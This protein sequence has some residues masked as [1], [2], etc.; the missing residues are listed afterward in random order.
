MSPLT[1]QTTTVL[2]ESF[3]L[4]VV[5]PAGWSEI[6]LNSSWAD[7]W[8]PAATIFPGTTMRAWVDDQNSVTADSLLVTPSLDFSSLSEA[9]VHFM[10]ETIYPTWR[11]NHPQSAG[12]GVSTVEYSV[13]GGVTWVVAWTD[14]TLAFGDQVWE[15]ADLSAAAGAPSVLVAFHYYGTDAHQWYVDNVVVD[16]D[17]FE[18]ATPWAVNLPTTFLSA[19][20]NEG[21][22][23][24]AGVLQPYMATTSVDCLT[25]QPDPTALCNIGQQNTIYYPPATGQFCLELGRETWSADTNHYSNAFVLGVDGQG[26]TSL[27]LNARIINFNDERDSLDGIWISEDGLG[28]YRLLLDWRDY[29]DS[30]WQN[31]TSI[32]L[33]NNGVD[34]GGQFYIMFGQEDQGA[35]FHDDGIGI[36]DIAVGSNTA[37]V[38]TIS[39]LV[40]GAQATFSISSAQAG[41]FVTIG[42]SL[43]GAGPTNTQY[44]FVDMTSPISVLA[45]LQANGQGV[46][47]ITLPV[48]ANAAGVTLFTQA[49]SGGNLTNSL[50]EIVQ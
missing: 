37:A 34:V 20:F 39:N 26:A 17:P 27:E 40:A 22:E 16:D 43:S 45:R 18:P 8:Q 15:N 10:T 4:G 47:S 29:N 41:D 13:D 7:G 38:Y 28:W 19:P 50:A 11:A 44:G 31:L 33:A 24:A 14:T 48:P 12:D 9:H 23:T 6:N 32:E 3:A 35:Y 49:L 1:A 2:E 25:W 21:F 46:A 30:S 5:P 36:D 42:Y